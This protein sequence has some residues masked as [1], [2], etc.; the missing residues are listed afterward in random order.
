MPPRRE[1]D[2]ATNPLQ[3]PAGPSTTSGD[4]SSRDNA[5]AATTKR[6]RGR[7][8][9]ASLNI[10][11]AG[12]ISGRNP[13][14]KWL[15]MH[16]LMKEKHI[17]VLAVQETHLTQENAD[18]LNELFESS[19]KIFVSPDPESPTSARG[20]A[21]VVNKKIFDV[22]SGVT[23]KQIIP[24]RALSISL[25]WGANASIQIINV[26]APNGPS[27]NARFWAEVDTRMLE[28]RGGRPDI[29][30]GDFNMVEAQ[31]D[32]APA[33]SDP[34]GTNASLATLRSNHNLID[35]WRRTNPGKRCFTFA[36]QATGSQSRI[37]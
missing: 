30:L 24:G 35:G 19:L 17:G 34:S 3:R 11:G 27:E 37:D 8:K 12:N 18:I 1:L 33:R 4:P 29:M 7:I 22:D 13:G 15:R 2:R 31:E 6:S 25:K 5:R 28:N 10:R 36:Q 9:V 16:Q 26:Y 14:E 20:V 32:R 23:V 21:T